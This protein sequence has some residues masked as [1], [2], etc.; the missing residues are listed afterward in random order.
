MIR[1][2]LFDLDD[3][4]IDHTTAIRA[5]VTELY[6]QRPEL[7]T[8]FTD[9]AAFQKAWVDVQD[10][11]YPAYLRGSMSHA[12]QKILRIRELWQPLANLTEEGCFQIYDH[13]QML[14]AKNWKIFPD[15]FPCLEAL[16]PLKIG[17]ISNGWGRQ[18]REKLELEGLGKK[19]EI[20]VIS[21]EVGMA[22]PEP[23]I[24]QMACAALGVS[25]SETIYVGDLYELDV[26]GPQQAGLLPVWL[27]RKAGHLESPGILT[28]RSLNELAA[29]VREQ[30][31]K[32]E[33][34]K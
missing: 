4:L 30:N 2:V 19:I 8:K 18:Q 29:L 3:T 23:R 5:A 20:V 13:F 24:F 25:P 17:L 6:A 32:R 14:Y 31:R 1:A 22:K 33:S 21:S 9:E 34:G 28:I 26:Q 27:R 7:T 12:E 11:Y 16:E 15:V 10:K